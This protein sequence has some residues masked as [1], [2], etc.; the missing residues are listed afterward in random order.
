MRFAGVLLLAAFIGGCDQTATTSAAG[1]QPQATCSAVSDLQV[2]PY[3]DDSGFKGYALARAGH[4]WFSAFGRVTSGKARISEGPGLVKVV[5]E[6]D[7]DLKSAVELTGTSCLS[8][9]ALRFCYETCKLPHDPPFSP[10]ELETMGSDRQAVAP[11][12]QLTG[13]LLCPLA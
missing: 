5:I 4:V 10:G 11:K 8:G 12:K 7:P 6:A 9:K 3:Q 1:S 13:Y 2:Y